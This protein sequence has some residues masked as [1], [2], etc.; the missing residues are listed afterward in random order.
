M[1]LVLW[2]M[3]SVSIY[4]ASYSFLFM[5]YKCVQNDTYI[6]CIYNVNVY[7]LYIHFS[8]HTQCFLQVL[9]PLS[10]PITATFDTF[11]SNTEVDVQVPALAFTLSPTTVRLIL[12][13]VKTLQPDSEVCTERGENVKLLLSL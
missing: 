1:Y 13:V 9:S 8:I 3:Q 11:S 7:V 6:I 10:E 5:H 2:C 4:I 12:K